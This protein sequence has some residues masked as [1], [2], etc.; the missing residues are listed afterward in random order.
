MSVSS[1]TKD[2]DWYSD[3]GVLLDELQRGRHKSVRRPE[4]DGY[5]DIRKIRRGGQGD[6]YSAFHR[7][8]KRRVAVKILLDRVTASEASRLRFEREIDLVAGLQHPNI[9]RVYDRGITIDGKPYFSMEHIDGLSLD[10]YLKTQGCIDPSP[11]IGSDAKIASPSRLS[12]LDDILMLFANICAAISHAHQRGVIHRDLKPSNILIDANG[13]PHILDFGLAK[14]INPEAAAAAQTVTQ[15]GEFMGTLAYAAPEQVAGDPSR[16]DIRTD[17]YALGVI[18][19]EMLTTRRPVSTA[20]PMADLIRAIVETEPA[21]PGIHDEIDTIV[22]KALA[23]EPDRRYQSAAALR[24]DVLR[25][26]RG[27]P[28]EAKRD[29]G[30]YLLKKTVQRYRLPISIGGVFVV[31]TILVAVAMSVMYGR[32]TAEAK[33][34]NQIRVFLEDTLAS[35]GPPIQGRDITLKEVLDEAEHWVEIALSDQPEIAAALHNTI[36]NSYRAL[37]RFEEAEEHYQVAIKTRRELL[38]DSHVEIAQSLNALALLRRDQGDYDEAERF[39]NEALS[40][41]RRL[42]GDND[43]EV[44][45]TLQN[46]G[47]LER[48]RGADYEQAGRLLREALAIRR[49]ALGE[50]HSD[51]AMCEYQMASLAEVRGDDT[52][53][54]RLHRTALRTRRTVLPPEHPDTARSLLSL[55]NLLVRTGRAS[56]AEGH[57]RACVEIMGHVVPADHWRRAEADSA[58]G[59]CL[60]DLRKF[61]EAEGLLQHSHRVFVKELGEDD[62][63]T[64]RVRQHLVDLYEVLDR[65]AE[66]AALR[67][68]GR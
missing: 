2:S 33:K 11:V 12:S 66:A 18:L 14:I 57:L 44:A 37:G 3:P 59:D 8:T 54:E 34:A 6:V 68:E 53:A 21:P 4:L 52:A 60:I 10:S 62:P 1:H 50:S 51:V 29:S 23:K 28:I 26:L 7:S 41:R 64:A 27:E 38:G 42:L 30:R 63:R 43:L 22:L 58:L 32:A 45:M 61:E 56:A 46:M 31:L 24:D 65:P 9:V 36:G 19:Y 5:E 47:I 39:L 20:M 55:G 48:L 13:E 17:V 35:V 67:E 40:M 15:T 25:F 16:V 49:A